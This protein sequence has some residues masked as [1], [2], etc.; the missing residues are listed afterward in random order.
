MHKRTNTINYY[1]KYKNKY[2]KDRL[3]EIETWEKN[4]NKI[5][6]HDSTELVKYPDYPKAFDYV[7]ELFPNIGIKDI[8]IFQVSKSILSKYGLGFCGGF[9]DKIGKNIFVCKNED[10]DFAKDGTSIWSR[11][12]SSI[13]EDEVIVHELLHYCFDYN[14]KK[15]DINLEEEF[16]YGNSLKYLLDKGY[17]ED[18]VIKNNYYPYLVDRNRSKII[19]SIVKNISKLEK[20]VEAVI[21]EK[22]KY[23]FDKT[24]EEA[25]KHG[26]TIIQ[27]YKKK[28]NIEDRPNTIIDDSYDCFDFIDLED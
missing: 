10:S 12:S 1:L 25:Y 11:I 4:L 20:D 17:T 24:C 21:K 19:K 6:N 23:I 2:K 14:G 26:E 3:Q 7:S 28:F 13:T 22:E 16:A 27:I 8:K 9:Y 15:I 18:E 5:I